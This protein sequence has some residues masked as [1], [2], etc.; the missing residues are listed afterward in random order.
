M[1]I[2][3]AN[4][5]DLHA[6]RTISRDRGQY[7]AQSIDAD[8]FEVE[9]RS[10]ISIENVFMQILKAFEQLEVGYDFFSF[11]WYCYE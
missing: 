9:A 8:Y 1:K 3:L 7:L 5:G 4:K 10:R 6:S 2:L 11:L